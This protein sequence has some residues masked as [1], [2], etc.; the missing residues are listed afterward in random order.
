MTSFRKIHVAGSLIV[1]ALLLSCSFSVDAACD[2]HEE[3]EQWNEGRCKVCFCHKETITCGVICGR[4]KA[5]RDAIGKTSDVQ[6][7]GNNLIAAALANSKDSCHHEGK[8]RNH[9][10]SWVETGNHA[11]LL[12]KDDQECMLCHCNKNIVSC[13]VRFCPPLS[14]SN[15]IRKEGS[16]CKYCPDQQQRVLSEKKVCESFGSTFHHQ[17]KWRVY[18]PNSDQNQ[19]LACTCQKTGCRSRLSCQ[20]MLCPVLT[21]RDQVNLP[22]RC[23]KVCKEDIKSRQISGYVKSDDEYFTSTQQHQSTGETYTLFDSLK[24]QPSRSEYQ[25]DEDDSSDEN[26]NDNNN[27]DNGDEAST[28]VH[29]DAKTRTVVVGSAGTSDHSSTSS[30]TS[31]S[32][33]QFFIKNTNNEKNEKRD[34]KDK[35]QHKNYKASRKDCDFGKVYKHG[36]AFI[37]EEFNCLRCT[38]TD[39]NVTCGRVFCPVTYPCKQPVRRKNLCCKVCNETS[40]KEALQ[41]EERDVRPLTKPR[42]SCGTR[43]EDRIQVFKYESPTS[44]LGGR[45]LQNYFLF[46]RSQMDPPGKSEIHSLK[47]TLPNMVDIAVHQSSSPSIAKWKYIGSV[48]TRV[49]ERIRRHE[50]KLKS[51]KTLQ[52]YKVLVKTI[53]DKAVK[54]KA[55]RR[56]GRCERK[57]EADDT[58][59]T[60]ELFKNLKEIKK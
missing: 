15:P 8:K 2:N 57:S 44:I 23:C 6:N 31:S 29:D 18:I 43:R 55:H 54:G 25:P 41:I 49:L 10:E 20:R 21:C 37:P 7:T 17:S 35:L 33:E 47:F 3:G 26:C 28:R 42:K 39:S 27:D 48:K 16:C 11:S 19:C 45:M 51:N 9:K 36:V 5:I 22:G 46:D 60:H 12:R 4:G 52:K 14:C 40:D 1:L 34:T 50:T 53:Q 32:I 56:S 13:T 59:A 30:S 38:C 58:L 24:D